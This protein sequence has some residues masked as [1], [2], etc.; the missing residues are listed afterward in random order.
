MKTILFAVFLIFLGQSSMAADLFF[1][2]VGKGGKLPAFCAQQ[3]EGG[4]FCSAQ[5]QKR[6]AVITFFRTDQT[7]SRKQLGVLQK[8]SDTFRAKE[9]AFVGIV[10]GPS[11]HQA[12]SRFQKENGITF[13]LLVDSSREVAGLFGLIA[14]PSTGI[15]AKDGTLHSFTASDWVS[16]N[17]TVEGQLRVLLQ[18][19]T[20]ADL[21]R[22]PALRPDT[23]PVGQS[24]AGA[25]YNMARMLYDRNDTA[26]AGK[27]LEESLARFPDHAPSQLLAGQLAL[28]NNE[29]KRAL[30]HFEQALRIDPN[31]VE[32]QKGLTTC[33]E[34]L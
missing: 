29:Y 16:F 6:I 31:L 14:V 13:P 11:D 19:M 25:Q 4:R 1:A 28:R 2:K 32:A 12:L 27:I 3:L 9:V 15:F 5:L 21:N 34:N 10:S 8:L 30:R 33:R 26:R 22:T 24:Q 18:Q 23:G 17:R 7:L 20:E